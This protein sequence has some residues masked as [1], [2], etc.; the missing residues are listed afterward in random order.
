[1][2]FRINH[3]LSSI[4][5]LRNLGKTESVVAKSLER[6]SSGLRV[7]RG[8]DDP[9]GLVISQN[10]RAQIGGI[11]QAIENAETA[12]AM[13]QT[14]EG[15]MNEIHNLLNNIR[16]LTIHAA[17]TGA[18]DSVML[19]ADQDEIDNAIATINRIAA[20]TQFGTKVLLDGSSG[21]AGTTTLSTVTFLNATEATVGGTYAIAVTVQAE[22]AAATAGTD[23]TAVL[24]ADETLTVNGVSVA[25]TAGMTQVQVVSAINDYNSSTQATASVVGGALTITTDGYGSGENASVVS[26]VAAA[27]TSSGV[28]TTAVTDT[29]V[30]IAGTIGT[31]AATGSGLVLTG[32]AGLAVEG[33][34]VS[35]A[36]GAGAAG[37]V[38]IT[39]NALVFQVG[40]N[41]GQTVEIALN[42]LTATGLGTSVSGNQFNNLSEISV[43][44]SSGSQDAIGVIDQAI[45][46]VSAKRGEL[47]VFQKNTLESTV[48]NL[49]I[50]EENLIAAESLIRD[51]DFASE[52][53]Q[54]TKNQI[55][56]QSGTAMLVQANQIPQVVLQLLQ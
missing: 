19:S 30:D 34:A 20:Q 25:L 2:S 45:Q 55:L 54:L 50:A 24:G 44:T 46:Q 51:V 18:N 48:S 49:A 10:M 43:L 26:S 9:A 47:G 33:I 31:L 32:D 35:T 29:G 36:L 40:A 7:N 1:M 27:T 17:N 14:A 39:D 15:A 5:A 12:T 13:I 38:T 56:L 16:E 42:A 53:A 4:N 52:M 3:N 21:M 37:S 8:A 6:L 41:A 23:Q 22:Q 28:G 11:Q